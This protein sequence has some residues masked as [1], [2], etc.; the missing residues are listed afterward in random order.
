MGVNNWSADSVLETKQETP[1][2]D[3]SE[4]DLVKLR[5]FFFT[6]KVFNGTFY[7]LREVKHLLVGRYRLPYR[8]FKRNQNLHFSSSHSSKSFDEFRH[9][10]GDFENTVTVCLDGV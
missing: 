4:I 3:I 10:N 1:F 6:V 2:T 7:L 5:Y 9:T 8:S